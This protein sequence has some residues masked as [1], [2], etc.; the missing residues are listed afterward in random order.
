MSG[1]RVAVVTGSSAGLGLAVA[2][3][4]LGRGWEVIGVARRP[5]PIRS[6]RYRQMR[7][8]LGEVDTAVPVLERELGPALGR[9][10]ATRVGLVNNAAATGA[11]GPLDRHDP[12][13]LLRLYAVNTVMPV[14]LMGLVLRTTPREVPVR[15][16]NVSSGAAVHPFPGLGAYC[17]AK[18]ALRMSGMV[19]GDELDSPLAP[20]GARPEVAVL[21]YEPGV[22][23]TEMQTG[24]RQTPAEKFPW[25]GTFKGFLEQGL[26]VSA[27]TSAAPIVEFLEGASRARF[28]EQ[29]L[30]G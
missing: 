17:G 9:P 23:D 12:H 2:N 10:E 11:L 7:V 29:R 21:S 22:V 8:D 15:I 27:E 1:D 24:A 6:D 4:L 20:G 26:L 5:A 30:G 25:V 18:A 3:Q 13:E 28:T 19:L 16:V 14:W